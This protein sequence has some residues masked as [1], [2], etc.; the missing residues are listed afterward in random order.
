MKHKFKLIKTANQ[1]TYRYQCVHCHLPIWVN[2]SLL[3]WKLRA[4]TAKQSEYRTALVVGG[5]KVMEDG[6]RD[7]E[8][9]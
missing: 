5:H 1:S 4:V 3:R 2:K 7:R 8:S 6:C 9:N